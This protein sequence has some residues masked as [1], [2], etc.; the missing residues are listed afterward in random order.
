MIAWKRT[1]RR[2]PEETTLVF[3]GD[4]WIA[5]LLPLWYVSRLLV[6]NIHLHPKIPYHEWL[7]QVRRMEQLR[8]DLQPS[9]T[10]LAGDLNAKD[11]PGTPLSSALSQSSPLHG[12]LRVLPTGTTTNHTTV[13]GVRRATAIDHVFIHGPVAEARHKLLSSRSSHA[14]IVITITLLTKYAD[15]W[16]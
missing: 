2:R 4:H 7:Q 8:R 6:L 15:A 16:A 11:S 14:V 3:D 13:K 9:Y 5:A 10:Y 1:L 12:Y